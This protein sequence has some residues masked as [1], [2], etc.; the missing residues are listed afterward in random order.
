MRKLFGALAA[1]ALAAPASSALAADIRL[2]VKAPVMAPVVYNWTGFYVGA[3]VGYSWG[4]VNT[5]LAASATTTTRTRIFRTAGPDL[6][7]DVTTVGLPVGIAGTGSTNV[8]GIIG[9]GQI[10]YNWQSGAW[11]FGL[12][13]DFQGSGEKGGHTLA[14][15]GLSASA[16]FKLNWFGTARARLGWLPTDRVVF[17]VTGG[18]A[19]GEL[20]SDYS[21]GFLGFPPVG[22]STKHTKAGYV[23]GGGVEGA[24][25]GNW[26]AKAEYLF[27][28]LGSFDSGAAT[29]A[30]ASTI[31][32]LNTP[33]TGFNTVID[34]TVAATGSFNNR[35]RDHIFRVGLNY[36]FAPEPIVARY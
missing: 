7:S 35:F 24:L 23:V 10:G 21:I 5:D 30:S 32:L 34:T 36:R 3:N 18:L 13:A 17:Y 19:Y 11:L 26:T 8:D 28:D 6:I 9:G 16:D 29:F 31:N 33:Q 25:G 27:M 2:P 14:I 20:Q 1:V 22:I 4:R 12:E 15:P